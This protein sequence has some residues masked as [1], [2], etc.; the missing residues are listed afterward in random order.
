[1]ADSFVQVAP[2]GAG[3]KVDTSQL[4]DGANTVERQRV[5]LGDDNDPNGLAGVDAGG[6]A[7]KDDTLIMLLAT[8][9]S[10]MPVL[11]TADQMRVSG[12]IT[13]SIAAAQTLATVTTVSNANIGSMGSLPS[14]TSVFDMMN[15]A[16]NQLYNSIAVT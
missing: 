14:N 11:D 16:A 5:V 4:V 6:L 8:M 1:M 9:L 7:T 12:S 10:R 13:A 15:M 2:D 3:K